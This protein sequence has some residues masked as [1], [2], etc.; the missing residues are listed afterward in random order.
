MKRIVINNFGPIKD[1]DIKFSKFL[2]LI[3]EQAT[4]KSTI[5]KLIY[6]FEELPV[7][8]GNNFAASPKH[9]MLASRDIAS[10]AQKRFNY[11]FGIQPE[12][13]I[14]FYYSPE[15]Y[16]RIYSGQRGAV[17]V[18]LSDSLKNSTQKKLIA[19]AAYEFLEVS[20]P[21]N[22]SDPTSKR[23]IFRQRSLLR[24]RIRRLFRNLFSSQLRDFTYIVA[25]RSTA[26]AYSDLFEKQLFS[27]IES[28]LDDEKSAAPAINNYL[29]KRYIELVSIIKDDLTNSGS[30]KYLLENE[31]NEV[32]RKYKRAA[33]A[34][35]RD[36]IKG[37]YI[38][39]ESGEYIDFGRGVIPLQDA[40]SGQQESIRILLHIFWSFMYDFVDELT[41]VEEPEAH[42]FPLAQQKIVA[43]LSLLANS[44]DYSTVVITTHSPYVL[45]TANQ[46]LLAG[47]ILLA[48]P[49]S[50][51]HIAPIVNPLY[52]LFPDRFDAYALMDAPGGTESQSLVDPDTG[53]VDANYLDSA[54]QQ[55]SSQFLS[56]LEI[57]RNASR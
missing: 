10:F 17:K 24:N 26:V 53:L 35:M 25:G 50:A 14:T 12:I 43:M 1:A 34:L 28:R 30:L 52:A 33:L 21:E 19:E 4:G 22:H 5:A 11:M 32:N 55:V 46:L 3:G 23:E 2:I 38:V 37:D 9:D 57:Y 7:M 54:S 56:L 8:A 47:K 15:I 6:F 27:A 45:T 39:S 36:I 18:Q 42:L 51:E 13:D 48:D 31:E 49:N 20:N 40:S 44:S 29:M 16:I 41:I